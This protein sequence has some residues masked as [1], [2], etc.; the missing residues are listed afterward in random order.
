MGQA[1]ALIIGAGNKV[2]ARPLVTDR[3]VGDKWIV[4][5]GLKA[6]DRII[7]EGL[8]FVRPGKQVEPVDMPAA[9]PRK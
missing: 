4:T 8:Q 7:V 9:S 5:D 6:G 2:E 3:A 1:M